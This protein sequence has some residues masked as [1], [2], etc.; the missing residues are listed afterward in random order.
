MSLQEDRHRESHSKAGTASCHRIQRNRP[1]CVERIEKSSVIC[2]SPSELNTTL[3]SLIMDH[4][5]HHHGNHAAA[6]ESFEAAA[7]RCTMNMLWNTQ[8]QVSRPYSVAH[9]AL[10]RIMVSFRTPASC[11]GHGTSITALTL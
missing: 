3:A 8:I 1:G 9:T 6:D 10:T 4:S 5:H 7:Q 11:S 2:A